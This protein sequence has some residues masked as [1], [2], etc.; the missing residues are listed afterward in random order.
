MPWNRS[1]AGVSRY[2]SS[3][4]PYFNQ[5]PADLMAVIT[6]HKMMSLLMTGSENGS[7][8]VVQAACKIGD[9]IEREVGRMLL[10]HSTTC[11]DNFLH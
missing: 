1:S 4:V 10:C 8:L 9:A 6:M 11:Y 2:K 5:L 7:V 3:L